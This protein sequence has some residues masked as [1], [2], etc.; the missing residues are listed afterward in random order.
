MATAGQRWCTPGQ[1]ECPHPGAAST[2]TGQL[3]KKEGKK[4]EGRNEPRL[5]LDALTA[6]GF[7]WS[8]G[9]PRAAQT[10]LPRGAG[11]ARRDAGVREGS[12]GLEKAVGAASTSG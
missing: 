6:S 2:T 12:S 10:C 8:R 11:Y 5:R 3:L 7:L 9:R 1:G 4:G